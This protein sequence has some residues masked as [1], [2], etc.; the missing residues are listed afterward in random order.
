MARS[1]TGWRRSAMNSIRAERESGRAGERESGR[2]GEG[3]R[4]KMAR[5]PWIDGEPQ[6]VVFDVNETLLDLQAMNALFERLFGD[7]RVLREWF[8]HLILSSMTITVSGL[9]ED[10]FSLGQGVLQMVGALFVGSG[11]TRHGP[12]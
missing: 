4:T 1:W 2:E 3:E 7:K 9:Y 6:V 11:A 5:G 8:G 12:R 10:F